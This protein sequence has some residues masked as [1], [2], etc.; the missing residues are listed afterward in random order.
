MEIDEFNERTLSALERVADALERKN[1]I[2]KAGM[3][4]ADVIKGVMV[5][6]LPFPSPPTIGD[7]V[8][9]DVPDPDYDPPTVW[10]CPNCGHETTKV[11]GMTWKVC[12]ECH[13]PIPE[14]PSDGVQ[15]G[16]EGP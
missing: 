13:H 12:G 16:R 14:D 1:E 7:V 2:E 8:H 5:N 11:K 9:V 6:L 15:E 10:T 4:I 3:E